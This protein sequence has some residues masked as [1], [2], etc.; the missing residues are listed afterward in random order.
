MIRNP[1]TNPFSPR[2]RVR[3]T[4]F[5]KIM[6]AESNVS[7]V[8][9]QTGSRN[10]FRLLICFKGIKQTVNELA[11]NKRIPRRAVAHPVIRLFAIPQNLLY[12][13]FTPFRAGSE[14]AFFSDRRVSRCGGDSSGK[15]RPQNDKEGAGL[16]PRFSPSSDFCGIAFIRLFV[17]SL[18]IRWQNFW[19][20][21]NPAPDVFYRC[22]F[23]RLGVN[24]LLIRC[25]KGFISFIPFICGRII[26]LRQEAAL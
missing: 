18:V 16:P 5:L 26:R 14:G 19:A 10:Y 22:K 13:P 9:E 7:D 11:T 4:P 15:V 3:T 17:Y 2:K 8:G 21:T 24:Y 20:E 12:H 1:V 25:R 6:A 23:D